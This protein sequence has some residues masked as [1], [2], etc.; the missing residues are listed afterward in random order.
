[1]KL[2]SPAAT[3]MEQISQ[4]ITEHSIPIK[5]AAA[6]ITEFA[7]H[8]TIVATGGTVSEIVANV[9]ETLTANFTTANAIN[10]TTA[11]IL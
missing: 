11:V 4:N 1:M 5:I 10:V 2:S 6:N 9:T 3:A 8:I 7:D